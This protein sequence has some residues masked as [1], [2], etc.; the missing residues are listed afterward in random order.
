MVRPAIQQRIE[1]Y[2]TREIRFNLMAVIA[3]RRIALSA[4]QNAVEKEKNMTV[5]KIQARSGKV[6]PAAELERLAAEHPPPAPMANTEAA[7]DERNVDQLLIALAHLTKRAGSISSQLEMEG[8]KVVQWKVENARRK[9]NY[10]PFIVNYLKIL[11]ERGELMPLVEAA[12]A[13]KKAKPS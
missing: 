12:K 8:Q 3:D 13:R 1:A 4:E 11:A 9:H 5:G 10:I 2:S 7:V 6:P